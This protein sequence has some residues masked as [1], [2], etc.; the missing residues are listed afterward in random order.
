MHK[1]NTRR[2]SVRVRAVR[3]PTTGTDRVRPAPEMQPRS[4]EQARPDTEETQTTPAIR[5]DLSPAA[6]PQS[7]GDMFFTASFGSVAGHGRPTQCAT[8][9]TVS[10]AWTNG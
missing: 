3:A 9:L 5:S 8:L 4:R 2:D 7:R 10:S 6:V 1:P